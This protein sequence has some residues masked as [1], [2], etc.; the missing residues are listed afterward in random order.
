[1]KIRKLNQAGFGHVE[2]LIGVVLVAAISFATWR[3][4]SSND[5]T[6]STPQASIESQE[7]LP[8]SLE[9]LKTLEEIQQIAGVSDSTS[10]IGFVLESK[11]G[12]YVYDIVLSN[13]KKISINAATGEIL[14]EETTDISDDDKLP[15][16][17]EVT[18]SPAQA[19][20]IASNQSDGDVK[21][22]ELEAEDDKVT[23]KVELEDGSKIEIDAGNGA[24]VKSEI[25][26]EKE[27]SDDEDSESKKREDEN[28]DES[29]SEDEYEDEQENEDEQDSGEDADA[30]EDDLEDS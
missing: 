14:S 29:E 25:K 7:L 27:S 30:D 24:I 3:V 23:Y 18:V 20:E 17:F 21:S 10:M 16:G 13:G 15:E 12:S 19:Y 1:M 26:D 11:D 28:E 8:E 5:E 22:I 6:T 4:I 2:L 9:E